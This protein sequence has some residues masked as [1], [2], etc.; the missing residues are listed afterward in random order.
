MITCRASWTLPDGRE[1]YANLVSAGWEKNDY[2]VPRSPVW[3][4]P[5]DPEVEYPVE[6]DGEDYTE[7][8]LR[9]EGVDTD[10]MEQ[11]LLERAEEWE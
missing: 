10:E 7:N 6:V 3:Y 1:V 5:A 9:E 8:R 4:E 2:G 11:Q